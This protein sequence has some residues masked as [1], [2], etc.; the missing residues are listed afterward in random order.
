MNDNSG[1]LEQQLLAIGQKAS[2]IIRDAELASNEYELE[3]KGEVLDAY[4]DDVADTVRIGLDQSI[5]I[6]TPWFFNNMPMIYYQTTP[7]AEKVRHLSSIISGHIFE[8]KQ[9]VELWNREKTKVT[10]IGPGNDRKILIDMAKRLTNLDLKLGALY[11]SHDNLLFL[12]TFITKGFRKADMSNKHIAV[13]LDAAKEAIL[14]DFSGPREDVEHFIEHLDHDFVMHGTAA[15][16]QNIF[17]MV[18]HMRSHESA[19]TFF[20]IQEDSPTARLS[21]GYKSVGTSDILEN[22][23]QIVT[24][25]GF[26]IVR[27]FMV[28]FDEGYKE[29]INVMNFVIKKRDGEKIE[30]SDVNVKKLIKAVRTLGWVDTDEYSIFSMEPELYSINAANYIRALATWSHIMLSKQNVYYYSEYKILTTFTSHSHITE[31]FIE[32]FRLKFDPLHQKARDAGGYI[33][34]RNDINIKI[35]E[36]LDQVEKT[37][38]QECLRFTDHLLKTN[39]FFPT[40][41][42]L[43][44][45]IS[46]DV[47][48]ST[49]YP[50]KPFGIF[51]IIGR[52]FRFF[53][54][55]WKDISRGGLRVVIPKN[56]SD[57]NYA[58][59]GLFDEVYGLSNA[60]Q[61]KNKDIPEGGSKAVMVLKPEAN[62]NR[63]VKGAINALLDLLVKEDES[64]EERNSKLVSYYKNEEIIYLGPDENV[65]NELI[66]WIAEQAQRRGYEYALAFMSSKPGAG[67]NHKEYG[68][69]SEGVQVFID[70][71]LRF[72]AIDPHKQ[73]FTVKMTGGPDGDV[74][75]NALKILHREYGE[76]ARILAIADGFGAAFDP[77]GLNWNELL[78]LVHDGHPISYFDKSKLSSDSN[79]FVILADT[80]ENIRKRNDLHFFVQSDLF[81]PAGGRPYSVNLKNYD[82]FL[83][84]QGQ[85]SCRAIVEGANIFFTAEARSKLEELGM[86]IIKD[87]TANK[88]G[89]IC[90]SFEIIAS[91]ILSENE[92]L[93]IK[94]VYVK[95]VIEILRHKAGLEANLLFREF[96]RQNGKAS[97]IDIS[98][99]ISKEINHVTDVMLDAFIKIRDQILS[100]RLLQK[101]IIKHCP[102]LLSEKYHDRLLQNLPDAHKIAILAAYMASYVVYS[103]G[104]G[105]LEHMS[106]EECYKAV[107]TY[108]RHV[109][110]AERLI[111][112][113][114]K[115]QI[116]DKKHIISILKKSAAKDLTILELEKVQS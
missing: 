37:I 112:D 5:A 55:R 97:M 43:A 83:N 48:D 115:S 42:G 71:T 89:V 114:Q 70:H 90:S 105:W 14:K 41:S 62:K 92:F 38:L 35:E 106:D 63:S 44:F 25:Y 73:R 23:L 111:Q 94:N 58:L 101:F 39:Y 33:A 84:N 45:R 65:S 87:S 15:R 59:A 69:T 19:H 81:L 77:N 61:L 86:I 34:K 60:Q 66:V 9:T 24:R 85:P 36:I 16:I 27:S 26:D 21:I 11:F 51:F 52:D 113:V 22:I 29:S 74:G 76:N 103:E 46:P 56:K 6:L 100:D 108:M 67:I 12:S 72:L 49:Y 78:R 82:K 4:I 80:N 20:E 98:Y 10:L 88:T 75:G 3:K 68:V 7:R 104:L 18:H 102:P 79:S 93:E 107:I 64:H 30:T 1:K 95:Q 99:K 2:K 110:D 32:L 47:L 109:E 17:R 53:H 57:H 13:K 50:Q 54:V 28:Q 40:K 8:T 31:D 96:V 91:L 116:V